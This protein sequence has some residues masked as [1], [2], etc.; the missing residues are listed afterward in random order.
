MS[1]CQTGLSVSMPKCQI[2]NSGL[3]QYSAEPFKQRQFGTAGVKGVNYCWRASHSIC[4][5]WF[6]N[7]CEWK[8]L[9]VVRLCIRNVRLQRVGI[10]SHLLSPSISNHGCKSLWFTPAFTLYRYVWIYSASLHY[11]NTRCK[12]IYICKEL[13]SINTVFLTL[14][15]PIPSRLCTLAYWSNPPF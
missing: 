13:H 5:T 1:E 8:G 2:K 14:S 15:P 7:K 6:C 3:D 10:C 4:S 12:F 11:A 9:Y